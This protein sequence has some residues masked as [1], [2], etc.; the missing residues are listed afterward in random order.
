MG[1]ACGISVQ[2]DAYRG[3]IEPLRFRFGLA[4]GNRLSIGVVGTYADSE[5]QLVVNDRRLPFSG[6]HVRSVLELLQIQDW[7]V[8]DQQPRVHLTTAIP[9]GGY[10]TSRYD[11]FDILSILDQLGA[12]CA[13]QPAIGIP[14]ENCDERRHVALIEGYRYVQKFLVSCKKEHAQLQRTIARCSGGPARAALA[15]IRSAAHA[16]LASQAPGVRGTT[17]SDNLASALLSLEQ[18]LRRAAIGERFANLQRRAQALELRRAKAAEKLRGGLASEQIKVLIR[19]VVEPGPCERVDILSTGD[20]GLKASVIASSEPSARAMSTRLETLRDSLPKLTFDIERQPGGD[21]RTPLSDT[22]DMVPNA[23]GKVA[24]IGNPTELVDIASLP[25]VGS[26][27]D[28]N[29]VAAEHPTLG[30]YFAPG[31]TPL[32][33]CR[34]DTN[35]GICRREAFGEQWELRVDRGGSYTGFLLLPTPAD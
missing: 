21:C 16:L 34:R 3:G 17:V 25:E 35:M 20:G 11:G 32:V 28:I 5:V 27:G 30:P 22:W 8:V 24:R 9:G 26:L 15:D 2:P 7:L 14:E 23:E 10:A 12:T 19:A 4:D 29:A 33:W 18:P 6:V 31:Q 1:S 13:R